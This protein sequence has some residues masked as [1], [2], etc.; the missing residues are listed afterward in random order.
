ME[1]QLNDMFGYSSQLRESSVW[2]PECVPLW[3]SFLV[4]LEAEED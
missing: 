3:I 4:G 1:I 2:N